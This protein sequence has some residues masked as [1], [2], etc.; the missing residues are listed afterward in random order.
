MPLDEKKKKR[1]KPASALSFDLDDEGESFEVKKS[2]PRGHKHARTRP[3][4]EATSGVDTAAGSSGGTYTAEH[5]QQLRAS[6]KFT[7]VPAA[8]PA[9]EPAEVRRA[10]LRLSRASCLGSARSSRPTPAHGLVSSVRS[11]SRAGASAKRRRHPQG[12]GGT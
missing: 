12:T 9:D 2:K 7:S 10:A 11:L 1:P 6:M 8:P 4:A 3:D 5:L